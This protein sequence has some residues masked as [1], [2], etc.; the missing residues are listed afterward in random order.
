MRIYELR[1]W[2]CIFSFLGSDRWLKGT[3]TTTT[4]QKVSHCKQK[5]R[6][7]FARKK[8][9][10]KVSFSSLF[11]CAIFLF[12]FI[13]TLVLPLCVRLTL[14]HTFACA[15][16]VWSFNKNIPFK[17]PNLISFPLVFVGVK[18]NVILNRMTDK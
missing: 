1:I 18:Y 6:N 17:W 16:S 14:F 11:M 10:L 13:Y 3:A 9:I 5:K 8:K 2:Y 12:S 4:T 7:Y 15:A